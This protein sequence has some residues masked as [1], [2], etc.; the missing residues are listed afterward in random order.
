MSEFGSVLAVLPRMQL[1]FKPRPQDKQANARMDEDRISAEKVVG[2][3]LKL[4]RILRWARACGHCGRLGTS[5]NLFCRECTIDLCSIAN[6]G[7]TLHQP[8]YPFRVSA[9]WTWN[10]EN[11]FL[12]KNMVHAFKRGFAAEFARSAAETLAFERDLYS[13]AR[14]IFVFPGARRR[15]H[16]WLLAWSLARIWREARVIALERESDPAVNQKE[17]S[18]S[19]R[20][21]IRFRSPE[22]EKISCLRADGSTFIVVDDVITSGSTAMA[23]YIALGEPSAYEVWTLACRPKLAG[24]SRF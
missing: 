22:E 7:E 17:L 11:T 10:D 6:R 3:R 13:D 8:G 12:V 14:P 2:H 19:E 21:R 24:K 20:T 18:L 23:A 4:D 5:V 16:A 15:D 1:D 9:L